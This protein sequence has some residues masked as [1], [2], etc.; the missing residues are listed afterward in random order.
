MTFGDGRDSFYWKEHFCM[1][2]KKFLKLVDLV[3]PVIAKKNTV[4][5]NPIPPRKQ[6]AIALRRLAVG[7]S[8]CAIAVH[9]DVGKSTCVTITKEFCQARNTLSRHYVKFSN[10]CDETT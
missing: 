9:F 7:S 3:S 4:L 1:R 6:V 10:N 8:F 5:R 2:K